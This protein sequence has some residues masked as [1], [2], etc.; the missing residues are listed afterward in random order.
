[1][2]ACRMGEPRQVRAGL[3]LCRQICF[4]WFKDTGESRVK[5]QIDRNGLASSGG[6]ATNADCQVIMVCRVSIYCTE[7][8]GH[9]NST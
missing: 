6:A 5:C 8:C 9:I 1:M 2:V 7:T 4:T 3:R